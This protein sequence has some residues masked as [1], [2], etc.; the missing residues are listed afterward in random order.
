LQLKFKF[1]G[2][3]MMQ[4]RFCFGIFRGSFLR[5]DFVGGVFWGDFREENFFEN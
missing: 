5:K 3:N 2:L 1:E 4:N